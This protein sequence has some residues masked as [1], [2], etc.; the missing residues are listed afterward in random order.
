MPVIVP[1]CM[2]SRSNTLIYPCEY[3]FVF[4]FVLPL[5]LVNVFFYVPCVVYLHVPY[6]DAIDG[7]TG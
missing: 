5:Y 2:M 1:L 3:V 6:S 7:E 4:C